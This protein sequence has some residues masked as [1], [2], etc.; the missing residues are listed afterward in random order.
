MFPPVSES[1]LNRSRLRHLDCRLPGFREL[2]ASIWTGF[3]RRNRSPESCGMDSGDFEWAA[4]R[5][6]PPSGPHGI[7]PC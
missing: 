5:S 3:K 2:N 4:T 7:P 6:I 1:K